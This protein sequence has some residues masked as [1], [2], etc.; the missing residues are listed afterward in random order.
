MKKTLILCDHCKKDIPYT[1]DPM[2]HHTTPLFVKRGNGI[3]RAEFDLCSECV[4]KMNELQTKTLE[5]YPLEVSFDDYDLKVKGTA[6]EMKIDN[7]DNKV[8]GQ[9][10]QEGISSGISIPWT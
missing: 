3:I 4:K 10:I 6:I 9:L 2:S 1:T 7:I 5:I 8:L